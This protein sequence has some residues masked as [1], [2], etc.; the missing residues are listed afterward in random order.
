MN[1]V[2]AIRRLTPTGRQM[3]GLWLV[4]AFVSCFFLYPLGKVVALSL[5]DAHGG[6]TLARFHAFATGT[7]LPRVLGQTFL[8]SVSVSVVCLVIGYPAAACLAGLTG[9]KSGLLGVL[10]LFPFLSNSLVRTFVFIVLLGR[11]GLLNQVLDYAGIPGTPVV[12]LFNEAGVIIGMS[13]VL[14]PYMILSLVGSMKSIDRRLLDAALS[15]GAGPLTV[16]WKIYLPLSL[17]GVVAGGVIT[18][19]LGFGYFV[20]PSLMGGPGQT[21]LAQL[22]EQQ[23]SVTLDL[24]GAAALAVVMLAVVA[25]GYGCACR[26]L[27]LS[28]LLGPS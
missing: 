27:G 11:R 4:L 26:W 1:P 8:T 16:F 17:P 28:R 13:Y 3:L 14:L 15:L 18:T 21:M 19:I 7:T 5:T 10:I 12:L 25:I 9:W 22:V 23:V 6:F 24:G 2:V 20:T